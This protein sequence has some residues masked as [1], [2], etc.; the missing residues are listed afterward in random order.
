MELI[1]DSPAGAGGACAGRGELG[2]M[3]ETVPHGGSFATPPR[4]W[5]EEGSPCGSCG[6]ILCIAQA[7]TTIFTVLVPLPHSP[8]FSTSLMRSGMLWLVFFT[9]LSA[10]SSFKVSKTSLKMVT[11]RNGLKK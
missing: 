11:M 1:R 10:F 4:A 3:G 7:H 2:H 5:E 9:S 8:L 6:I